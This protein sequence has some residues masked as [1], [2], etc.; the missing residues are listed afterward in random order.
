MT[1][2]DTCIQLAR[3][4]TAYL[5]NNIGVDSDTPSLRTRYG[6]SRKR[7][8][9]NT[10]PPDL[11]WLERL[12]NTSRQSAFYKIHRTHYN[13]APTDK[14]PYE[15]NLE[16][17][18]TRRNNKIAVDSRTIVV[19]MCIF[20]PVLSDFVGCREL[21]LIRFSRQIRDNDCQPLWGI[22]LKPSPCLIG[23]IRPMGLRA[24]ARSYP[25]R[26]TCRVEFGEANNSSLNYNNCFLR[27]S[28]QPGQVT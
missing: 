16:I 18:N 13:F 9:L 2:R 28:A 11:N 24:L 27:Q 6:W 4:F 10:C 23:N 21:T 25:E 1:S 15:K 20:T 19:K 22:R 3:P 5:I 12:T 26:Y 8:Y 17:P 7:T 14:L